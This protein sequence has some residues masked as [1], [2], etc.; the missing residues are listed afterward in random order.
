LSHFTGRFALFKEQQVGVFQASGSAS[1]EGGKFAA[2]PSNILVALILLILLFVGLFYYT[3]KLDVKSRLH[4]VH[5]LA[6]CE[7]V[8]LLGYI[9]SA[10]GRDFTLDAFLHKKIIKAA[11]E[12]NDLHPLSELRDKDSESMATNLKEVV[13]SLPSSPQKLG[14]AS[15]VHE[16][17][18]REDDFINSFL[19]A[20]RF[21]YNSVALGHQVV[22]AL[23]RR[24]VGVSDT[25]LNSVLSPMSARSLKW[26]EYLRANIV[27]PPRQ[28]IT[29]RF[30][31]TT[32][33]C[34]HC[35]AV[36]ASSGLG[37]NESKSLNSKFSRTAA[38]LS[39]VRET[40]QHPS[41]FGRVCS[42]RLMLFNICVLRLA[43]RHQYVYPFSSI[44]D[45]MLPRF[46][47]T[48]SLFY[49]IVLTFWLTCFLFAF[50]NGDPG[51]GLAVPNSVPAFE[52]SAYILSVGIVLKSFF[53]SVTW[54]FLTEATSSEFAHRYPFLHSEIIRRKTIDEWF[55]KLSR[56]AA[57]AEQDARGKGGAAVGVAEIIE[58]RQASM[59]LKVGALPVAI[60]MEKLVDIFNSAEEKSL[61]A[62]RKLLADNDSS[63]FSGITQESWV[64][65]VIVGAQLGFFIAYLVLFSLWIPAGSIGFLTFLQI[66]LDDFIFDPLETVFFFILTAV[67]LPA[68][69]MGN[70]QQKSLFHH[71]FHG[72]SGFY[73]GLY[74]HG[75]YPT[76]A[77]RLIHFLIPQAAQRSTHGDS[78]EASSLAAF[79]PSTLSHCL[80]VAIAGDPEENGNVGDLGAG[81]ILTTFRQ[82]S[83]AY[84]VLRLRS[85]ESV[86]PPPPPLHP[87]QAFP[88]MPD[89]QDTIVPP[90][91][92][93]PTV[94]PRRILA[95]NIGKL[96]LEALSPQRSSTSTAKLLKD[97]SEKFLLSHSSTSDREAL[98]IDN[99]ESTTEPCRP[100]L[101][102]DLPL[103][104]ATPPGPLPFRDHSHLIPHPP[105]P[106]LPPQ[107]TAS[108]RSTVNIGKLV[109]EALAFHS[110]PTTPT[111][112]LPLNSS[113]TILSQFHP[114]ENPSE[115]GGS[116]KLQGT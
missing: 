87:F 95:R 54:F 89:P 56:K 9:E 90:P 70:R 41:F 66:I 29:L 44:M 83:N 65:F 80:A 63:W 16:N 24:S 35:C 62:L 113:E 37:A 74:H 78:I 69:T 96:V 1:N 88:L 43:T 106:A 48:L 32:F 79:D 112:N 101:L 104:W 6:V 111:A 14:L 52:D 103:A 67:H 108:P 45:P 3:H 46:Y 94:P 110:R 91:P 49:G 15:A 98:A 105:Q 115:L 116:P 5:E 97:I 68:T 4:F 19:L 23:D 31:P 64:F 76:L 39:S 12:G 34:T 25:T 53:F 17:H 75:T 18:Q 60:T 81:G 114:K 73:T 47:Q 8:R 72:L 58:T 30:F 77:G 86:S 42:L 82:L 107:P 85:L 40:L 33:L 57:K 21:H 2:Q 92:P 38:F 55:K 51:K 28:R 102:P 93:P 11:E 99:Q 10:A 50:K 59:G 7:D 36:N 100:I 13:D 61:E 109:L 20:I 22:S 27:H 84:L 26:L 71:F